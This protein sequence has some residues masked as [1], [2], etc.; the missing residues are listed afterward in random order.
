MLATLELR[1]PAHHRSDTSDRSPGTGRPHAPRN[2]TFD[3]GVLFSTPRV[4]RAI[5]SVKRKRTE[6]HVASLA[7]LGTTRAPSVRDEHVIMVLHC[8]IFCACLSIVHTSR[9]TLGTTQHLWHSH[10]VTN[11][12]EGSQRSAELPRCHTA[13][14]RDDR[15]YGPAATA[16][17]KDRRARAVPLKVCSESVHGFA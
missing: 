2:V 17:P 6:L 4:C 5:A 8:D 15:T 10:V 16:A 9:F 11:A 3:A 13:A 1:G 12:A 14:R 7:G